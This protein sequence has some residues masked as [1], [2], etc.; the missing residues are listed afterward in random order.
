MRNIVFAVMVYVLLLTGTSAWAQVEIGRA[1]EGHTNAAASNGPAEGVRSVILAGSPAFAMDV[2]PGVNL[3]N[4]PDTDAPGTWSVVANQPGSNYF[5]G[6]FINGDFSQLYVID[7]SLNQLH[8]LDTATG[9]VQVIGSCQPL[10]GE[11]WT[12][13]SG[14]LNGVCV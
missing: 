9:A 1:P 14:S 7:Y 8:A 3:V 12:G 5:A 4:I 10:A 2:Y 11:S 13:M 6:D